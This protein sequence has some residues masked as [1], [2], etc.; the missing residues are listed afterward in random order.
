MK[1]SK[2]SQNL[3]RNSSQTSQFSNG[4]RVKQYQKNNNFITQVYIF[5][6]KLGEEL[7]DKANLFFKSFLSTDFKS[8]EN[9]ETIEIDGANSKYDLDP[10][11]YFNLNPKDF[12]CISDNFKEVDS[13]QFSATFISKKELR[14]LDEEAQWLIY[15]LENNCDSLLNARQQ[16][17]RGHIY[18]LINRFSPLI[19][20]DPKNFH[21]DAFVDK[22]LKIRSEVTAGLVSGANLFNCITNAPIL[23][24]ALNNFGNIPAIIISLFLNSILLNWTNHCGTAAACHKPGNKHWS[25]TAALG[26]LI[27]GLLQSTIS[28]IGIELFNNRPALRQI[29]AEEIIDKQ[30]DKIEKLKLQVDSSRSELAKEECKAKEE[31]LDKLSPDHPRYDSLYTRV[32]GQWKDLN[33]DWSKVDIENLPLCIKAER[34]EREAHSLVEKAN[35]EWIEKLENRAKIGNDLEFIKRNIYEVYNQYFTND[36]EFKSGVEA[37]RLSFENFFGKLTNLEFYKLGLSLVLWVFSLVTSIVACCMTIQH[38]QSEDTKMSRNPEVKAAIQDWLEDIQRDYIRQYYNSVYKPDQTDYT[39]LLT[40]SNNSNEDE[41][42]E[43]W[44]YG[45]KLIA[46]FRQNY[47]ESG[48]CDYSSLQEIA[49]GVHRKSWLLPKVAQ[50]NLL[51]LEQAIADIEKSVSVINENLTSL[52]EYLN[53]PDI[54]KRKNTENCQKLIQKNTLWISRRMSLILLISQTYADTAVQ[55]FIHEIKDNF[56]QYLNEHTRLYRISAMQN[57]GITDINYIHRLSECLVGLH[58]RITFLADSIQQN[59]HSKVPGLKFVPPTWGDENGEV[60]S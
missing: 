57:N 45:K 24:Y 51:A 56:N 19:F 30:T 17:K 47:E 9:S 55:P 3:K 11:Q 32:R 49:R 33:R 41:Y 16:K 42:K 52:E 58:Y 36:D 46:L 54:D 12:V 40:K 18:Q 22:N 29:L 4:Y 35:Q 6:E 23:Y 8:G 37:V 48:Y 28:G 43:Q 38:A 39:Y 14:S 5:V 10:N 31:E 15:Y 27:M 26:F 50:R 59:I 34:L 21:G 53:N 20:A 13:V 1:S 7:I 25:N 2:F 44:A 60:D